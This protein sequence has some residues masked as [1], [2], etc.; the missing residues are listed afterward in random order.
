MKTKNKVIISPGEHC[1]IRAVQNDDP[2]LE[3]VD[4]RAWDIL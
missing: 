1:Y 3:Q 4:T 2:E